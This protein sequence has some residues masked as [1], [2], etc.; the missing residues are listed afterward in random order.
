MK[1]KYENAADRNFTLIE[2]LI[3]ISIIAILAS[4]LLPALNRTKE[5]AV[6][7]QCLGKLKQVGIAILSYRNDYN[8]FWISNNCSSSVIQS[9]GVLLYPWALKLAECGYMAND[10]KGFMCPNMLKH[11]GEI[12]FTYANSYGAPYL[13][14]TT[15]DPANTYAFDLKA[16]QIQTVGQSRVVLVMDSARFA[17]SISGYVEGSEVNRIIPGGDVKNYGHVYL[18]HTGRASLLFSDGHA[19]TGGPYDLRREFG[20]LNSYNGALSIVNF[21]HIAVGK[22]GMVQ[23][24][25]ASSITY[26]Q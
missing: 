8:D 6:G 16:K 10:A 11:S 9:G 23:C 1:K 19:G 5:K 21:A 24:Q 7:I 12:T 17:G 15:S 18:A 20:T 26:A 22:W 13:N 4:L 2:L 25:S 14:P 3:V